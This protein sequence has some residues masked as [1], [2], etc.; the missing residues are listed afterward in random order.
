[1]NAPNAAAQPRVSLV[2]PTR[3][4]GFYLEH[5]LRSCTRTP[6]QDVEILVIDNASTDNTADVV[7]AF[8]DPRLRYIRN[9]RRLSMRDNFERGLEEARGDIICMIGD[10]DAILPSAVETTLDLLAD[11]SVAAVSCHRAYYGWPDLRSGRSGMALVPRA[12]GVSWLSSRTELSRVLDHADYYRLPCIYHGFVRRAPVERIRARQGRFFLS[13]NVDI[14]SA[15]ALSM[16]GL[17]Y[18]YSAAPLVVNGGSARSNG[19]SHYGG[20]PELEKQLWVQEDDLGFLPGF[21]DTL[22]V[23][24]AIVETGLRY[25]AANGVPIDQIF[26]RKSLLRC[27]GREVRRREAAGRP[28][29]PSLAML[30]A[31][32]LTAADVA[33]VPAPRSSRLASLAHAFGRTVPIDLQREAINTVDGAA[34]AIEQRVKCSRTGFLTSLP[35]QIRDALQLTGRI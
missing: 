9:E 25:G 19:A 24:A 23:D 32:G 4:R 26:E 17:H 2:L 31:S 5:A 29:E 13:N 11:Q 15:I 10:D 16:E 27:L 3:E 7:T 8:K 35:T 6:L 12:T 33:D 28:A 14:Y 1:M 18:A 34:M 20:A 21:E 30:A 22:A